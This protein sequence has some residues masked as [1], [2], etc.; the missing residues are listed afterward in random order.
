MSRGQEDSWNGGPPPPPPGRHVRAQGQV[1]RHLPA[2]TRLGPAAGALW[3]PCKVSFW[4]LPPR[5]PYWGSGSARRARVTS[6]GHPDRGLPLRDQGAR[7]PNSGSPLPKFPFQLGRLGQQQGHGTG[8]ALSPRT[9]RGVPLAGDPLTRNTPSRAGLLYRRPAD[10]PRQSAG[11]GSGE[12]NTPRWAR[13][14]CVP[15]RKR[16]ELETHCRPPTNNTTNLAVISCVGA[17]KNICVGSRVHFLKSGSAVGHPRVWRVGGYG[18]IW[19]G[20]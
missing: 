6:G 13:V 4:R 5:F 18:R 10:S 15:L 2:T 7:L 8:A 12:R 3:K 11:L 20:G 16:P 9:R 1:Q 17:R 14:L 19:V